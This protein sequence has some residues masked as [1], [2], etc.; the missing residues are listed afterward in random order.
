MVSA[1]W[2]A[3]GTENE[4]VAPESA[5]PIFSTIERYFRTAERRLSR[6][7]PESDIGRLNQSHSWTP[8]SSLAFRLLWAADRWWRRTEGIF[9]PY[10]LPALLA[11]G[12]DRPFDA[13]RSENR[14]AM[15]PSA[16]APGR[17]KTPA[18]GEAPGEVKPP[19]PPF[20][21]SEPRT[22]GGRLP[23]PGSFD[24]KAPP[25]RFDVRRRRIE[26]RPDVAVDLGGI[27]KGWVGREV[28]FRLRRAGVRLGALSAGGDLVVWNDAD[29]LPWTVEIEPPAD[30]DGDPPPGPFRLRRGAA[31]T[32]G[33]HR[34][35]W[36]AD[37]PKHHLIDPSTGRPAESDV[38]QATVLAADPVEAEALAK[39]PI[40]L[41]AKDGI[42]WLEAYARRDRRSGLVVLL[43][44]DGRWHVRRFAPTPPA[45]NRR[46]PGDA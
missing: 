32:S 33:V 5:R 28:A 22:R 19:A 30:F 27:A 14:P 1:R 21:A 13:L 7:L 40:V 26:R 17:P 8:V 43:T 38:L 36:T 12:Y 10:V 2:A 24:P 41:G 31:A 4:L 15:R 45:P 25:L 3:M 23:A 9:S 29:D 46:P 42:A 18:T 20:P 37:G 16:G 11:A 6:F 44:V 34:R 39:I 35:R